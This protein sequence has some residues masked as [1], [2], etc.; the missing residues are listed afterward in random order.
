M[1]IVLTEG[2]YIY[3]IYIT[4]KSLLSQKSSGLLRCC[5]CQPSVEEY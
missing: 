2:A 4:Q 3:Y 1:V 5:Y